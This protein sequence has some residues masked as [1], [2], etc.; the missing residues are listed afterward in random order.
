MGSITK[1]LLAKGFGRLTPALGVAALGATLGAQPNATTPADPDRPRIALET[2]GPAQIRERLAAALTAR[3][4]PLIDPTWLAKRD[5]AQPQGGLASVEILVRAE[6]RATKDRHQQGRFRVTD[7]IDVRVV[8]ARTGETIYAASPLAK[9]QSFDGYAE[10]HECAIEEIFAANGGPIAQLLAA[11]DRRYEA[12][13][14]RGVDMILSLGD[15]TGRNVAVRVAA[16]LAKIDGVDATSVEPF[17]SN[18][19]DTM[20]LRFRYRGSR[21]ALLPALVERIVAIDKETSIRFASNPRQI[22]IEIEPIPEEPEPAPQ[23]PDA[24][25]VKPATA[26]LDR[27]VGGVVTDA[28]DPSRTALAERD[29]R[30]ETAIDNPDYLGG[31]VARAP[32]IAVGLAFEAGLAISVRRGTSRTLLDGAVFRALDG[33]A[34]TVVRTRLSRVGARFL[35]EAAVEDRSRRPHVRI[36]HRGRIVG[37]PT[38]R[39]ALREILVR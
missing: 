3:S 37:E 13:R 4:H 6:L 32:R 15:R 8:D 23:A 27:E 12:E 9:G 7:R 33:N 21:A 17:D 10:A 31:D 38:L 19:I 35:L 20:G 30:V 28:V 24:P 25:P 11:L 39:R 16:D 5:A 14:A 18:A 34:T 22:A 26:A 36:A 1:S 2:K 29:G